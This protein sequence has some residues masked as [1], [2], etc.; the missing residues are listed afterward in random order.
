MDI[1]IRQE[2]ELDYPFV[3]NLIKE[4]FLKDP[5]SDN[6]EQFL[7][8]KLRKSKNYIPELSLVAVL[9]DEIVGHILLTPIEIKN[10]HSE[11]PSLT[12]APVSV[13]PKHQNKGIGGKLIREAHAKAIALGFESI[14]LLGHENYYPKF[15]YTKA[16]QFNIKFPFEAPDENCMAI[17]LTTDSLKDISGVIVYPPEFME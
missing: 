17:E 4:A 2:Q 13:L 1:L 8:E 7:V 3:F 5:H 6:R 12:L 11:F 10:D 9:K 16:S 14:V 15:G